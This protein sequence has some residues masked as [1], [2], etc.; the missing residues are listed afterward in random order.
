MRSCGGGPASVEKA[1]SAM[2]I[3]VCTELALGAPEGRATPTA[4]GSWFP[5]RRTVRVATSGWTSR[6]A[7][8]LLSPHD[9][10]LASWDPVA[11]AV[12][13]RRATPADRAAIA[14]LFDLH[15]RS[16]GCAP[17]PELDSDMLDLSAS[18]DAFVV[19]VIGGS[20]VGMGGIGRGE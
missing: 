9:E 5:S 17:D 14:S 2:A 8:K 6:S 11:G 20:V 1:A 10:P 13:L 3:I 19:A 16:L 18:Y 15:L 12:T 4:L 7:T